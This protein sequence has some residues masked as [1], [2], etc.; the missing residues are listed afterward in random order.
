[1]MI[2]IYTTGQVAKIL[3]VAPRTVTKCFDSGKLKGYRIPGSSARRIPHDS[4]VKFMSEN[5]IP[6]NLLGENDESRTVAVS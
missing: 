4:L 3:G 2:K 5:Q 1:M 6:L